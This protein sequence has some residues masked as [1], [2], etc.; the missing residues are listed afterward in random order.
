V[1]LLL[2]P[3]DVGVVLCYAA[4]TNGG[5]QQ[6]PAATLKAALAKTLVTYYPLARVIS[7]KLHPCYQ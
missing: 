1:D 3:L 6:H 2:L 5:S 4:D 7:S